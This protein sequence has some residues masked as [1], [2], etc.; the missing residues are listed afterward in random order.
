MKKYKLIKEYP[1]SPKLGTEV[2]KPHEFY[3][4]SGIP[5]IAAHKIENYPDFWEEIVEKEYEI[6]AIKNNN[7]GFIGTKRASGGFSFNPNREADT[8]RP[9]VDFYLD[10]NR[11]NTYSIHSI[12]RLS[13]GEI[14]SV[15]DN[16]QHINNVTYPYGI[17]TKIHQLSSDAIFIETNNGKN[18]FD[19]NMCYV[20]K[21]KT[22]LFKTEDGVDIFKGDKYYWVNIYFKIV[23][24]IAHS[25]TKSAKEYGV[26]VKAD[27]S[28]KEAAEEY[29]IMHKPC[30]SINDIIEKS[31]LNKPISKIKE[32]V[33]S[34]L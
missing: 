19:T 2:S 20:K 9:D 30:L 32:L 33:K 15:G 22:P 3:C 18:G 17:I 10:N 13:D 25:E 26:H 6:I 28:T 7:S 24:D 11:S 8:D 1:G 27:F 34:R 29:I 5:S 16:V 4:A 23:E 31:I 12:K 14:F 21:T